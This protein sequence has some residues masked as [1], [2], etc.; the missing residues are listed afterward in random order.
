MT[1][2]PDC[3]NDM[4]DVVGDVALCS[5]CR[6]ARPYYTRTRGTDITPSQ[7][8]AIETVKRFF[9]AYAGVDDL[10][11][12]DVRMSSGTVW[13]S[14]HTNVNPYLDIGGHF[15]IGRRGAI[16][17]ASVYD[18]VKDKRGTAEFYARRLGGKLIPWAW[19]K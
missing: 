15:M 2:C 13:V 5:N 16:G 10:N 7:Q 3:G 17:V 18:L 14:V 4:W 12:F 1:V 6:F 19:E 9:V 8:E 11:V